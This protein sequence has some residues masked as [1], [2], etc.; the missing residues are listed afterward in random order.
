MA[1]PIVER[2]SRTL[3]LDDSPSDLMPEPA[4]GQP[5][6][7]PTD[8]F[9]D[10]IIRSKVRA[11]VLRE[12]TLPRARL[13]EWMDQHADQRVRMLVAEAGYGKTTLLADWARRT[14]RPV[15]WLKLDPSDAE[16]ALFIGY[17]IAAFQEGS[18]EFGAATL[19]LLGHVATLGV[20]RDQATAQLLAELGGI[21]SEPT[22]LIIDDVQHVA[23]NEDVQHIIG[24]LLE[25]APQNL[26]LVLSGRV[27]PELRLGRLSAQGGVVSLDTDDLRFTRQELGD[28]F[29]IGY[30]MPLDTDLLGV[31]DDK[32]EGWAA[33]LQLLH[34]SLRGHR[35]AE[36]RA[37]ITVMGGT[38]RPLYDFLAEEVLG[39]QEPF[40]Q[41]V[42][43]HASVADRVIVSWVTAA[44]SVLADPPTSDV[45]E[46]SLATADELGL[47]SRNA[48]NASSRRFHPL[49]QEFL[50]EHLRKSIPPETMRQIHV[51]IARAAEDGHWPT[52]AH[53]F[54]EAG[55]GAEAMR[56]IG[57]SSVVALGTGAWDAASRLLDRV[58]GVE[59][60]AA[61]TVLIARTMAGRGQADDALRMLEAGLTKP[62]LTSRDRALMQFS[63]ASALART[64]RHKEVGHALS[65]V[66]AEPDAPSALHAV[67]RAWL[68]MLE[69]AANAQMVESLNSLL[70]T[71]Q[72][73]KLHYFH[74][75]ALH[76]I[77]TTKLAQGDLEGAL[78]AAQAA[79]RAFE[80]ADQDDGV[81][82]STL[83]VIAHALFDMGLAEEALSKAEEAVA[84]PA[85]QPDVFADAAMLHCWT[86]QADLAYA[87]IRRARETFR[88][89]SYE[90]NAGDTVE[91]GHA[92][93]ALAEGDLAPTA[94]LAQPPDLSMG[95][96]NYIG[97]MLLLKATASLTEASTVS[98]VRND[99]P[100]D[101][102]RTAEELKLYRWTPAL[103]YLTDIA[104]RNKRSIAS[105]F[106]APDKHFDAVLLMTAEATMTAIA[107]MDEPPTTLSRSVS[108]R[109]A[110]WR[111][112][113]RQAVAIAGS[114]SGYAAASL[115]AAVGEAE[116][117]V[118][119]Q[120]W[121]KRQRKWLRDGRYSD[122]LARRISPTLVIHD[123][124]QTALNLGPRSVP[125]TGVRRRA[126]TLLLYLVSRPR[127]TATRDQVLDALWPEQDPVGA[128]N[129]LHQTLF[130]LRRELVITPKASKPLVE[131]VPVAGDMIR[132]VP[133]L[134]HVDSVSFLRQAN[135]VV[136]RH[137]GGAEAVR[138]VQSYA[139]PFAPE[140]EYDEW[141]L[142]WRDH[143][144]TA[145]LNLAEQSARARMPERSAEAA[146]ILRHA[147]G[148]DPDALDLKPLLAA[149]MYL[150]GSQAAARHLY[151]QYE[152]EHDREFGVAASGLQEVLADVTRGH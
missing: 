9:Q 5:G 129:S 68:Q 97:L 147:L 92:V 47:M 33:S 14:I 91:A 32:T 40:M 42:L 72:Q 103:S 146:A 93:V 41:Q 1:Q 95:D 116:D 46:T 139:G 25:R 114:G 73:E 45:V 124:G 52:A 76:N 74:G 89:G 30:G 136:T 132:L 99:T 2:A 115:L 78:E 105:F 145:F 48:K 104:N 37:F 62:E 4:T 140:F 77:A 82:A 135:E 6:D 58:Q 70:P 152:L 27:T 12:S 28:L 122:D 11:P 64:S 148:V 118:R 113:L 120:D 67:A 125:I 81:R 26:T 79:E 107:A 18:P 56:V 111:T 13:L 134:V 102:L 19:R 80:L 59:R 143:V 119:L 117:V 50:R 60:S 10:I 22:V 29:S 128:G 39:H 51:A 100:A 35:K 21:I 55:E 84:V 44:M 63:R 16:W 61:V 49:L 15:R 88:A 150:S 123:L 17:L 144:H 149:A 101:A 94:S 54:I 96:P 8:P 133:E 36:I 137:P 53:H 121:E 138:L 66:L 24:R 141:A 7:R 109:P 85:A 108:R 112:A 31:V 23:G 75:L 110:R 131:Y 130:F 127:Q 106:A 71:L 86:G 90:V 43:L 83:M 20:T 65:V 3:A 126:A 151:R 87:R 34:S 57:D 98:A 142:S 69:P 38:Q